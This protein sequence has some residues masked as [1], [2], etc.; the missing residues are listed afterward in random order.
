LKYN[1]QMILKRV[2]DI[3]FTF[4]LLVVLA[5][6]LL[7]I[8]IAIKIDS[9]GPI[10]FRQ[11]RVGKGGKIF[12]ILK[13]RTMYTGTEKE[14]LGYHTNSNDPRITRVGRFLRYL[15]LD[16]LPQLFNVLKG[17][18]SVVGPRPTL[19]YQVDEY[20]EFQRRRLE[21]RPGITGLAQI[22]GRNALSWPER[23][24][25]DVK[26]IDNRYFLLDLKIIIKTLI[27]LI[28]REGIYS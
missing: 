26:Y 19:K 20:T 23:I 21:L 3:F 9:R 13:F 25:I 27:Q 18:M 28:K 4:I 6:P 14:G 15:S 22:S 17:E 7:I 5:I 8:A 24:K 2:F 11:E 1:K 10:F 16:E 12:K